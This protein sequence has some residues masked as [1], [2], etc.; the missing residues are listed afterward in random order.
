[1]ACM[2]RTGGEGALRRQYVKVQGSV[3]QGRAGALGVVYGPHVS[4]SWALELLKTDVKV[5]GSLAWGLGAHR[6][7]NEWGRVGETGSC[8]A[9]CGQFVR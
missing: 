4:Y 5:Q 3:A 1:M 2:C 8:A 6:S 7:G 9:N